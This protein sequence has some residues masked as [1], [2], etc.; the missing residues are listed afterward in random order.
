MVPMILKI[1]GLLV[2]TCPKKHRIMSR[3]LWVC[4]LLTQVPLDQSTI[5]HPWVYTSNNHHLIRKVTCH[6]K[7]P[8][9]T[10]SKLTR[11]RE[12]K[13]FI[14]IS[15][16]MTQKIR[17][18][19]P[20]RIRLEGKG[21]SQLTPLLRLTDRETTC[22]RTTPPLEIKYQIQMLNCLREKH[23]LCRQRPSSQ[24]ERTPKIL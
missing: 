19:S 11:Y 14:G 13:R 10:S 16:L 4:L 6:L 20:Q 9:I 17:V 2:D 22:P 15:L 3:G 5:K 21:K 8:K 18:F 7:T 1:K 12:K 23:L 24:R